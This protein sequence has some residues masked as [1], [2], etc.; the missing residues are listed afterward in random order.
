MKK[1]YPALL[2]L[3]ILAAPVFSQDVPAKLHALLDAYAHQNGFNGT[4]LVAR[5]GKI[6]LNKGYGCRDVKDSIRNDEHTIF[7]L[8][9]LTKQFTATLIL[10][11]QEER[12]L[13]I[14]DKISKYF[15]DYPKADSI[16]IEN[17][18][19]HTSGIFN[20]TND[21]TFMANEVTKPAGREKIFALFRDKPLQFTPGTQFSYSN[22]GYMLLGYIIADV[23]KM[24][25]E[26]AMRKYIFGPLGMHHSGF[27]F[28]GLV[29]PEKATGYFNLTDEGNAPA[30]AVDS[31]VSF[32]AGAIYSTTGDLYKWHHAL[33]QNKIITAASL[34]KAH[35]PL[36]S[37]YGYGWNID[38]VAGKKKIQH[39]GG[40][41]GFN[42]HMA[43]VLEDDVC[44]VLLSNVANPRLETITKSIVAIL[45]DM[46]YET[47]KQRTAITL[48]AAT[49]EQYTGVYELAPDFRITF[50][51]KDGQ[52]TG[53]PTNQSVAKLYAE[54]ED[55]FFLKV[56]D[57]Q[58]GFT[59]DST[60]TINGLILYQNGRE[61]KGRK[62][63]AE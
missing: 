19:T 39:G 59:R 45:Y 20:Y 2:C 14:Q 61:R 44:I 22:S 54:K 12:K 13:N 31:S 52:L 35:T 55:F 62:L 53:Q 33:R 23:T 21:Q 38:T 58:V 48:P 24:P 27:D 8:G 30:T 25:Y 37:D 32:A 50:K 49:L 40:I 9:S 57:A 29:S 51:V 15:P 17:L 46:P 26:Q 5:Q 28:T 56:V 36:K 10:K 34:E 43:N 1:I 7:Q 47:P 4:A 16:T 63:P 42:T 11:L 60:Q 18:L 41:H 3:L 6:L